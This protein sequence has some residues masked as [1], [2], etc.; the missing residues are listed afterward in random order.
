MLLI[1][2][3]TLM[4]ANKDLATAQRSDEQEN[5][6]MRIEYSHFKKEV[7]FWCRTSTKFLTYGL[8]MVE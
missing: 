2:Y 6:D 1:R 3:K 7:S 4:D 5:E 8:L